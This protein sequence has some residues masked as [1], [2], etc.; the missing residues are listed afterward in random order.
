[1]SGLNFGKKVWLDGKIIDFENAHVSILSHALHYGSCVF[2]G[3]RTYKTKKGS[4]IFRLE[5]HIRRLYESAKIYR[6][7]IP[8]SQKEYCDSGSA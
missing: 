1:M 5:D 3:L 4:A 2:E 8:L 7:D 6:M